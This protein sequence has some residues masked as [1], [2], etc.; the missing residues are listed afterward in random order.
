[1]PEVNSLTL[2]PLVETR[3]RRRRRRRRSGQ[4]DMANF[5]DMDKRYLEKRP[6]V[7]VF[8]AG[9]NA[10]CYRIPAIVL[11]A[12]GSLLAF[13]EARWGVD[14]AHCSGRT[15]QEIAVR[16]STTF[17]RTWEP[18][19]A[20]AGGATNPVGNPMPIALRSGRVVL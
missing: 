10:P 13:A 7:Q 11:T 4:E 8:A 18:E 12:K 20:A 6:F 1:M 14:H 17:G 19:T 9:D 15:T 16:R 2:Q 5:D 3:R